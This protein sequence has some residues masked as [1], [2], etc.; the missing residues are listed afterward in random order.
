MELISADQVREEV[1]R[2]W[3][4]FSSKAKD[5]FETMYMPTATVFAVDGRRAELARLTVVRRARELMSESS[6]VATKLGFIEVQVL[7]PN[8][9]V[10]S[11][12]LQFSTTRNLPN[13]HRY[14]AEIP[15]LRATQVFVRDS[16]SPL[17]IIH[18]HLSSAA[19]VTITELK[20]GK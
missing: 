20:P 5:Q 1:R 17:R 4:A 15:Y 3:R 18:E 8:V 6:S 12:P 16:A 19:P 11:Y 14:R 7:G 9:V 13:G 2:F 10:A